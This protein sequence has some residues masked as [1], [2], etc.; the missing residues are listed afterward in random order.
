[1]AND[2]NGIDIDD[3]GYVKIA[4]CPQNHGAS[5]LL[6]SSGAGNFYVCRGC[7]KFYTPAEVHKEIKETIAVL[8]ARA[9]LAPK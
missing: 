7:S 3:K 1:M 2:R 8:R 4:E 9:G 5:H 6:T